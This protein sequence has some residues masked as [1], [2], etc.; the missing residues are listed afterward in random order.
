MAEETLAVSFELSA[1][2]V[3]YFR[4]QL[5]EVR[6]NRD[7]E[8]EQEV[9]ADTESMI[10]DAIA[11]EPPEFVLAKLKSLEELVEMLRDE[12][13]RL[14]GR[15]RGRVLDAIAYFAKPEDLIPDQIP[16]IGY[17]DDAIMIE[18]V[19]RELKHEIKAY[20]DFCEFRGRPKMEASADKLERRRKDLQARMRRRRR[21]ERQTMRG[22][23]SPRK[24]S[25]R[26]W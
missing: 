15:D 14:D 6:T 11:S 24:T 8:N 25:L 5:K 19:T 18:L 22:R 20:Q 4:D 7:E 3:R 12:D 9:I 21:H 16:G 17:I 13:W 23:G 26:L 1:R 10:L 2:D